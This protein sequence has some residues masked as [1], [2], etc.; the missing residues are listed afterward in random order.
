MSLY[1]NDE[2]VNEHTLSNPIYKWVGAGLAKI[3]ASEKDYV[4]K[5]VKPQ[6][7]SSNGMVE[8]SKRRTISMVDYH[9]NPQTSLEEEWKCV[10]GVM[11]SYMVKP[12]DKIFEK[13]LIL[14]PKKDT[15]LIFYLSEISRF[16]HKLNG[17]GVSGASFYR[18]EDREV[19]AKKKLENKTAEAEI[20]ALITADF[21]PISVKSTGSDKALRELASAW[22]VTGAEELGINELKAALIERVNYFEETKVVSR[23]GYKEFRRDCSD[24]SGN[25]ISESVKVATVVQRAMEKSIVHYTDRKWLLTVDGSY[26]CDVPIGEEDRTKDVLVKYFMED[27]QGKDKYKMVKGKIFS[28]DNGLDDL[29]EIKKATHHIAIKNIAKRNGIE[30]QEGESHHDVKAR[31]IRKLEEQNG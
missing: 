2:K 8:K 20:V 15:E 24:L 14:N 6:R 23:R 17:E 9:A 10:D 22:G 31:V 13:S 4:F 3:R 12:K 7:M 28:D 16:R 27:A 29:E 11:P 26:I 21:S 1:I 18:L 5:D 19:E 30:K 25:N